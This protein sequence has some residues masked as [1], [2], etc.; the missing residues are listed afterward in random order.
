MACSGTALLLLTL[1]LLGMS[2][3]CLMY[4]VRKSEV[5]LH[6]VRSAYAVKIKIVIIGS[7]AL[8]GPWPSSEAFASWSIR[9]LLLQISWQECFPGWG[10]LAC[11]EWVRNL[12]ARSKGRDCVR[13]L[14]KIF[15]P[16]KDKAVEGLGKF[17]TEDRNNLYYS[18]Y[19]GDF[20]HDGRG[21]KVGLHW[22]TV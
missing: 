11:S 5:R 2:C 20:Y 1:T 9:L 3:S 13:V 12:V 4:K 6:P 21:H 7:T 15:E 18:P 14:N 19:G 10:L 17:H 22:K 8:L 16:T